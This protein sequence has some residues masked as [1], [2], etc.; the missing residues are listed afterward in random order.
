[1][2]RP[3]ACAPSA[4]S[5]PRPVRPRGT[6]ALTGVKR[7]RSAPC[8]EP[9]ASSWPKPPRTSGRSGD[10][11]ARPSGAC[12][13]PADVTAYA[14][15]RRPRRSPRSYAPGPATRLDGVPP[16][17]GSRHTPASESAMYSSSSA[18]P[19][20]GRWTLSPEAGDLDR[21]VVTSSELTT[22]RSLRSRNPV[23]PVFRHRK[24]LSPDT[25]H[26]SARGMPTI[27]SSVYPGTNPLDT[28]TRAAYTS[29]NP[30]FR[31]G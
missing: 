28:A 8:F 6:A 12:S 18:C 22:Q 25:E 14:V 26:S 29:S 15:K 24:C 23:Q 10:E 19:A 9:S 11:T 20:P 30:L 7:G 21:P 3:G 27:A 16:V 2:S 4:C 13:A 5:S 1:V 17:A 31:R